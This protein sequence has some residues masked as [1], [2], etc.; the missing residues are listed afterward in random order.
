MSTFVYH[1]T[2]E[3][4]SM[5]YS[6][7]RQLARANVEVCQQWP[8]MGFE[9]WDPSEWVYASFVERMENTTFP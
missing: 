6:R 2:P 5:V 4:N 9:V 8:M 3:W 7:E 1:G